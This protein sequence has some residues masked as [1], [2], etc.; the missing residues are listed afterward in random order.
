VH[1]GDEDHVIISPRVATAVEVAQP[2]RVFKLA[3]LVLDPPA[4]LREEH[5]SL[6]AASGTLKS[7]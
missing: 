4:R 1:D 3:V 2:K 6:S 7:Q 5:Q